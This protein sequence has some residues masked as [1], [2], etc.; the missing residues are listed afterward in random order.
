[1][2]C[3]LRYPKILRERG[4]GRDFWYEA[5][6]M[7]EM[8]ETLFWEPIRYEGMPPKKFSNIQ[9]DFFDTVYISIYFF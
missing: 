7:S 5:E 3:S 8:Q 2:S 6:K 1:M 9:N 4:G